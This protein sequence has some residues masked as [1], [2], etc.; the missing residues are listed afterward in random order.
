M[1]AKRIFISYDYDND[2]HYKNLLVAWDKNKDFDFN[3]YDGSV[4]VAVDSTDAGYI[5]SQIKRQIEASTHLLCL[6]GK[7]THK[8]KWIDWEI[9]TAIQLKKKLIAVKIEKD[10]VTPPVLLNVGAT[11][12]LSFNFDAIK[13]A[14]EL[15]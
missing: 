9:R 5:K 15:A 2:R 6:V 1:V 13:I 8:S 7:N 10:N 3:F 12:A 11:W 14:V 4:T